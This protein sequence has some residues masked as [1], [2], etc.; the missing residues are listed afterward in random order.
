MQLSNYSTCMPLIAAFTEY[1]TFDNADEINNQV[2]F[3]KTDDGITFTKADGYPWEIV[4]PETTIAD[5]EKRRGDHLYACTN[6][7]LACKLL[8]G[9]MVEVRC[10]IDWDNPKIP[11]MLTDLSLLVTAETMLSMFYVKK[12]GC[13]DPICLAMTVKTSDSWRIAF[14]NK[15]IVDLD[16]DVPDAIVIVKLR[17]S[18]AYPRPDI[19]GHPI[20]NDNFAVSYQLGEQP[21]SLRG[22][23]IDASDEAKERAITTRGD[24]KTGERAKKIKKTINNTSTA[25]NPPPATNKREDQPLILR[26]GN[27]DATDAD[28]EKESKTTV[29]TRTKK[30]TKKTKKAKD[31]ITLKMPPP[32]TNARAPP[33]TPS[34]YN[35]KETCKPIPHCTNKRDNVPHPS[36]Y[37]A[38]MCGIDAENLRANIIYIMILGPLL[39]MWNVDRS[40]IDTTSDQFQ[41]NLGLCHGYC[42]LQCGERNIANQMTRSDREISRTEVQN[43]LKLYTGSRILTQHNCSARQNYVLQNKCSMGVNRVWMIESCRDDDGRLSSTYFG[44]VY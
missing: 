30:G 36:A 41:V 40:S 44:R 20:D 21:E 31:A 28:R 18:P 23:K 5:L 12:D 32:T 2:I 38:P 8:E 35:Y 1:R 6:I 7:G 9:Q 14:P 19:L 33:T 34:P 22:G 24:K 13:P 27:V 11:S 29:G 15:T 4:D 10:I 3:N 43:R 37:Q 16:L 25:N 17:N 42:R 39:S 26:G